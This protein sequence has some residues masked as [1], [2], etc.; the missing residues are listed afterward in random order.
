MRNTLSVFDWRLV[1]KMKSTKASGAEAQSTNSIYYVSNVDDVQF[2]KLTF[3]YHASFK[4]ERSDL[5][6]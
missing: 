3:T 4:F 6:L 5:I 1:L 2:K